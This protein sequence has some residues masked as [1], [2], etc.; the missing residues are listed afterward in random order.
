M[1]VRSTIQRCRPTASTSQGFPAIKLRAS[2]P[3]VRAVQQPSSAA[4][5]RLFFDSGSMRSAAC[6]MQDLHGTRPALSICSCTHPSTLLPSHMLALWRTGRLMG[7][8]TV[9]PRGRQ[10]GCDDWSCQNLPGHGPGRGSSSTARDCG[11]T[12]QVRVCLHP[13]PWLFSTVLRA[14][15]CTSN[16]APWRQHTS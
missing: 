4:E 3:R 1:L 8:A 15:S 11:Q 12:T 13:M 10:A 16:P 2:L 7:Q 9:P 14:K 5:V 6:L